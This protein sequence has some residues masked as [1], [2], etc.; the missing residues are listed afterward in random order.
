M[1]SSDNN[2]IYVCNVLTL[3][4]FMTTTIKGLSIRK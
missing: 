3:I 2:S 1:M 4:P